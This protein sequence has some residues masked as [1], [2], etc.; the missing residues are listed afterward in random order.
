LRPS[1]KITVIIKKKEKKK[2]KEKEDNCSDLL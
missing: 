2:E 1:K